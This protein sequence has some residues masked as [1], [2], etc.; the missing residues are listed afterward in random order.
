M[1]HKLMDF[2]LNGAGIIEASAGTGKTYTITWLLCRLLLG[3]GT[4]DNKPVDYSKILIMTFTK[5]A[6]NDLKRKI[7]ERI[8]ELRSF[9]E[10]LLKKSCA[11]PAD[12]SEILS[13]DS[14]ESEMLRAYLGLTLVSD[15]LKD[16]EVREDYLKKMIQ[17]IR[18]LRHVELN[19]DGMQISTIHS[20]CRQ[21]ISKFVVDTGMNFQFDVMTDVEDL[22]KKALY[23]SFRR[24]MVTEAES[25]NN[26]YSKIYDYFLED[27]KKFNHLCNIFNS[28]RDLPEIKQVSTE[29]F[30][31]LG[32]EKLHALLCE[33]YTILEQL[34]A[35]E[36]VVKADDLPCKLRDALVINGND[37]ETTV[38]SKKYLAGKIRSILPVAIIDEFQDT[39]PVQFEIVKN[40]YLTD[41]EKKNDEMDSCKSSDFWGLYIV[42]D[43]KQAIYSFR[44]ADLNCYNKAKKLI[45]DRYGSEKERKCHQLELD[46]NYRSDINVIRSVNY[47]F[48][49]VHP[50][51][52]N[53]SGDAEGAKFDFYKSLLS[54]DKKIKD[55]ISFTNV[56]PR[57]SEKAQKYLYIVG[58]KNF[59]TESACNLMH[60]LIDEKSK[61]KDYIY[62]EIAEECADKIV[63]LLE[64]G[65]LSDRADL[66][67][68]QLNNPDENPELCR[69][70][71]LKDIAVLV[72]KGK[73][74]EYINDSLRNRHVPSVFLSD[75]GSIYDTEE[76]RFVSLLMKSVVNFADHS[77]L[78][79]LLASR[80]FGLDAREYSDAVCNSYKKDDTDNQQ[81]TSG[82][83]GITMET[84][85]SVLVE[86][87]QKWLTQGFMAMF[88]HFMTRFNIMEKMKMREEGAEI[89]TNLLHCS[90]LALGLSNRIR[91]LSELVESFESLGNQVKSTDNESDMTGKRQTDDC[92]EIVRIVTYHSSKGLEYNIVMMPFADM[93]HSIDPQSVDMIRVKS[94]DDEHDDTSYYL[95]TKD[96]RSTDKE[97]GKWNNHCYEQ[98]VERHR[99]WYVALTRAC[100]A[101]YIWYID[102][103][104]YNKKE[105]REFCL[106]EIL[107]KNVYGNDEN[108]I[109]E[110]SKYFRK[111]DDYR[112]GWQDKY[113]SDE[114]AFYYSRQESN[115]IR[116]GYEYQILDADSINNRWKVFSYSSMVNGMGN[117]VAVNRI[118]GKTND[119]DD[120]VSAEEIAESGNQTTKEPRFAF[121]K[122]STAGTLLHDALEHIDFRKVYADFMDHCGSQKVIDFLN[123]D[124][125]N[126]TMLYQ[127]LKGRLM[128]YGFVS[129]TET[130]RGLTW[131]FMEILSSVLFKDGESGKQVALKDL[132]DSDCI[133]E[134]EFWLNVDAGFNIKAFNK[135]IREIDREGCSSPLI[136]YAEYESQNESDNPLLPEVSISDISGL[137]NGYIDLVFKCGD[138]YYVADYKSNYIT[139]RIGSYDNK[140]IRKNMINH[141]YYIQYILYTLALHRF[142]KLH[143]PDYDYERHMGGIAYLY[144]RGMKSSSDKYA[145][146]GIFTNKITGEYIEKLDALFSGAGEQ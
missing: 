108:S 115:G 98:K 91:D 20:F 88:T 60:S 42:G 41:S 95:V 74:A 71:T 82:N 75:K 79:L 56:K 104:E 19:V 78:R 110:N 144:L 22:K 29:A 117:A 43:P 132:D 38:K 99:L 51:E 62:S 120:P 131:W 26:E 17:A 116:N 3:I 111:C 127:T 92:D 72:S 76:F 81:N 10:N 25:G 65:R 58:N 46:V 84:L 100:H 90:E 21:V 63:E 39:D 94:T 4:S 16:R 141:H 146:Y 35:G 28:Y 97:G 139:D 53:N 87:K 126:E 112:A 27:G 14:I 101:L 54:G 15:D 145:G 123:T 11:S 31:E 121:P 36:K 138:R 55:S 125:V 140:E 102:P 109:F 70:I 7:C 1:S 30:K 143:L 142:L 69:R 96:N 68:E 2:N 32:I 122:G 73:E 124:N 77:Y 18:I 50:D 133:K 136:D 64:N 105:V 40:I 134:M 137:L 119:N 118:S 61:N 106:D 83:S 113:K 67:L 129:D 34:K 52:Q 8:R 48:S 66:T 33:A 103:E 9:I 57:D 49:G 24:F 6:T 107:F 89:I 44:G 135:L 37:D 45:L 114:A 80:V 128:A 23:E 13:D 86:C 59:K 12:F 5:A 130:V 93:I 85:N 47:L